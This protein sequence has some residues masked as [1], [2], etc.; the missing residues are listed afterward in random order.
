V[1]IALA[2]GCLGTALGIQAV[3]S[4][5]MLD[6]LLFGLELSVRPPPMPIAVGWI[7]VFV[8]T[9]GAATPAVVNLSRRKTRELLAAR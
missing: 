4:G 8:V 2:A 3:V 6:K 9:I 7:A 5:Q 1:L